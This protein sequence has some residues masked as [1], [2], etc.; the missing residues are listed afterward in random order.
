MKSQTSDF[1]IS[2]IFTNEEIFVI[3]MD[4]YLLCGSLK[5]SN[6]FKYNFKSKK[7]ENSHE[8]VEI[9]KSYEENY[10]FL[11]TNFFFFLNLEILCFSFYFCLSFCLLFFEE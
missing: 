6:E 7:I 2:N 5:N 3:T 4:S 1:R 11:R 8:V 9:L 10:N